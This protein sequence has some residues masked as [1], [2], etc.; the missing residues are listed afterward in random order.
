MSEIKRELP[1]ISFCMPNYNDGDTIGKAIES[2][3]D[4]DY[5]SIEMIICDDGSTDKSKK[6][7]RKYEKK[8]KKLKVIYSRHKGACIARNLAAKEASGKYLS[9]LPADAVLYPGVVRT[10]INHLEANPE[11]EFLYGGYRFV[12]EDRKPVFNYMSEPFDEFLLKVNNYIDGSFPLTKDLFDRIGGWDPNLKSL[13]DWDLWLNA[14]IK[15]KAKGF[16]LPEIFFETTVPHEGGL[17]DDSSKN[18][19]DRTEQIKNK[20]GIETPE[21]CVTSKGADFHG[22]RVAKIL[23]ADYK[24]APEFKPHNYSLIYE[25]GF[26]PSIADQC[27]A[28]FQ[29][30]NGL[31]V[32]HWIGSDIWQMQ[33]LSTFHKNLLIDWVKN[34]VDLNLTEFETTQKELEK[35]GIKSKI[36]P[37]PPVRYFDITPLPKDF[38]VAVYMPHQNQGFYLP[39]LIKEVAKQCPKITFKFFGD[40]AEKGKKKNI[41]YLGKLDEKEMEVLIANSSCLLRVLPHDG[42]A[43]TVEEFLTAG[44][45]IVTNIEG[46]DG[47]NVVKPEPVVIAKKLKKLSKLNKPDVKNAEKWRKKLSHK[48]FKKFFQKVLNYDPEKYWETR[49]RSWNAIQED[50]VFDKDVVTKELKKLN[51]KSVLDIGCGNG[52]WAK[53][54]KEELG[55]VDYLG[56][57]ISKKMVSYAQKR[58]PEMNFKHMDVREVGA[59]GKKY[60]LIFAYTCFLHVPK[61][62]MKETV[63]QLKKVGKQIL[64]VEPIKEGAKQQFRVLHPELIKEFDKGKVI[65][66]PKAIHIHRYEEFFDKIIKKRDLDSRALY[67]A[68]L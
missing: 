53:T 2:I 10:W 8:F 49:A 51:P 64:F 32:V 34:N 65:L 1:L 16:Y 12:D 18:W 45:R 38:T 56:I 42:L 48:K 68:D 59:L 15:E 60:D 17:S 30:H 33:Q 50:E 3:M 22:K 41:Q 19:V 11:F 31:R 24:M 7:L 36:V 28:V 20:Y 63:K 29:G 67:I 47:A 21:I 54:I 61:E 40:F 43:I 25:L 4:Q 6:I 46:I 62:D 58:N 5:P 52:N 57:D 26:Y 14:V 13:Q 39:D 23:G 44:R 66:N 35:E 9:F 55:D 27:G 37:I